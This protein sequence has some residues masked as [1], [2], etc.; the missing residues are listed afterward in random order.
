MDPRFAPWLQKAIREDQAV[1]GSAAS[2]AAYGAGGYGLAFPTSPNPVLVFGAVAVVGG[3]IY[4][5]VKGRK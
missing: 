3:F 4:W 1:R 5:L 2:Q